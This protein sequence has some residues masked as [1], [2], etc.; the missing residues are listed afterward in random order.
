MNAL[1]EWEYLIN[2]FTLRKRKWVHFQI[3]FH[4]HQSYFMDM[5]VIT[6]DRKI[7]V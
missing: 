3:H 6:G 1:N 4:G 5:Q 2:P 7:N